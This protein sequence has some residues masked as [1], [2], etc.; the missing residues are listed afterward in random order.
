MVPVALTP[1]HLRSRRA[2]HAVLVLAAALLLGAC[3]T[4]AKVPVAKVP[5]AKAPVA[6]GPQGPSLADR[7]E[8]GLGLPGPDISDRLKAFS[9]TPYVRPDPLDC[10]QLA[11]EIGELDQIL[12]PD[13]D[14]KEVPEDRGQQ[15]ESAAGSA[16]LGL[17][18]YR[19]VV[20]WMSG[21]GAQERIRARAVLA[22]A[23][24]RGFLKGLSMA[25]ACPAP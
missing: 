6:P 21:A 11:R 7:A 22:A 25:L 3:A 18:P 13:V 9:A 8:T 1:T 10:P 15:M 20:R 4:T 16:L 2:R 19:G 5:A 17:I 12:G 14:L 24:R 23:A